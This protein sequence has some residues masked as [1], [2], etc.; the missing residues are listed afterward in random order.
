MGGTCPAG[1]RHFGDLGDPNSDVSILVKE[2]GGFDLMPEQGNKP[3]NKYLPPRARTPLGE[4]TSFAGSEVSTED[5]TGLLGWIDR[6]LSGATRS[7]GA[8]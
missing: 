8:N 3:V 1:A 7:K 6:A 4:G 2:R 5:A